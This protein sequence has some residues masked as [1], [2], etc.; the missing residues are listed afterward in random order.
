[1]KWTITIKPLHAALNAWAWSA[2]RADQEST[3][4]GAGLQTKEAAR[5]A[6]R[7]AINDFENSVGI[8]KAAT[9]TEEFLPDGVTE[10]EPEPDPETTVAP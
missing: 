2:V 7:T 9:V 8:I 4:G 5:Q 10:P 3:L 6:A 1:M